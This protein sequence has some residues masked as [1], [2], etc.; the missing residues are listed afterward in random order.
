MVL[1]AWQAVQ[2]AGTAEEPNARAGGPAE[3]AAGGPAEAAADEPAAEVV[4]EARPRLLDEEQRAGAHQHLDAL[5]EE[6][7]ERR[8]LARAVREEAEAL[9]LEAA[10]RAPA[11]EDEDAHQ[12]PLEEAAEADLHA[13][14]QEEAE[15]RHQS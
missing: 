15:G 3:E 5:E 7:K 8:P 6:A 13:S 14:E 11:L 10:Q 2:D 9:P 12:R 4:V 1:E